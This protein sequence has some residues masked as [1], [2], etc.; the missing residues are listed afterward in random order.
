[1]QLGLSCQCQGE[2]TKKPLSVSRR[3][4]GGIW[5]SIRLLTVYEPITE[6]GREGGRGEEGEG[7]RKECP[8]SERKD[9]PFA[10]FVNKSEEDR[11]RAMAHF[12]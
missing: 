11:A 1:M 5:H 4:G 3:G 8:E 2:R 12:L 7:G 6:G 9:A 10:M